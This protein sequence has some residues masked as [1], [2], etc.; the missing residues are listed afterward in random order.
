MLRFLKVLLWIACL[1]PA[2]WLVHAALTD[3][4]GAN[5]IEKITLVTGKTALTILL[6]TLAVTPFR[7]VSRWNPVI[8]LRRPLGLFAFFYVVLHLLT[9]VTL[10]LYFDFAAVGEDILKRPYITVGFAAFVLLIPLA[11]TSTKGWIRK[12]GRRWQTLHTLVYVS[13]VLAVLHFFWKTKADFREV[14]VYAAVLI[15]L[16]VSRVPEWIRR[17]KSRQPARRESAA[18]SAVD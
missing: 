2:A 4:L 17:R 12:L 11:V 9:Y 13:A 18:A 5:P 15:V 6:V 1:G 14:G 16:L 10:D 7:R 8:Q 3:G